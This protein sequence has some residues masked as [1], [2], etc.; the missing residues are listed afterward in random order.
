MP[1]ALGGAQAQVGSLFPL[2]DFHEKLFHYSPPPG[3]GN[4]CMFISKR[5][6]LAKCN[7]KNGRLG[8]KA[9]RL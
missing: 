8:E 1:P 4:L 7:V 5:F 2:L 6:S 3:N 9:A